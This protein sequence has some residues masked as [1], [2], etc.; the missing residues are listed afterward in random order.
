MSDLTQLLETF[1]FAPE[2]P[3]NNLDSLYIMMILDRLLLQSLIT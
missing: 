2:D 1:I 3:K